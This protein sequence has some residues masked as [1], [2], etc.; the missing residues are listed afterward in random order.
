MAHAA[1]SAASVIDRH[2][3][4]AIRGRWFE[5]FAGFEVSARRRSR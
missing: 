4:G 1:V 2:V 5:I 3:V